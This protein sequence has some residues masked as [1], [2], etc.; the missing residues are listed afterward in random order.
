M[1]CSLHRLNLEFDS[2]VLLWA[3]ASSPLLLLTNWHLQISLARHFG[4]HDTCSQ[5]LPY[6][7]WR[8][9]FGFH[10]QWWTH[11]ESAQRLLLKFTVDPSYMVHYGG[12]YYKINPNPI[13]NPSC[14]IYEGPTKFTSLANLNGALLF[15]LI[16]CR[17]NIL[18]PV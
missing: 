8:S 13:I 14:T 12:A 9:I 15:C 16:N 5:L 6:T 3:V 11:S 2:L 10:W 18:R 1:W 17:L 4:T 7:I